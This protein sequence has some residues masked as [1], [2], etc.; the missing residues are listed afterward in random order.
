MT[1]AFAHRAHLNLWASISH[2]ADYNQSIGP[3]LTL[4]DRSHSI[5]ARRLPSILLLCFVL[6]A[7]PI[8]ISAQTPDPAPLRSVAATKNVSTTARNK[9][10]N[11]SIARV[12]DQAAGGSSYF[13]RF[14]RGVLRV[15]KAVLS[16]FGEDKNSSKESSSSAATEPDELNLDAR[17]G[18]KAKY[19]DVF[20]AVPAPLRTRLVERLKLL[21]DYQRTQQWEKQYDLLSELVTQGKGKDEFVKLNRHYYTE[22]V[23]D[24]LILDFTPHSLTAQSESVDYGEWTIFGCARLQKKGHTLQLY[25]SVSAYRQNNDW[26]FSQVGLVMQ[27]GGQ[28]ENCPYE[29]RK[30]Q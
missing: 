8:V 12:P 1:R 10:A 30:S 11:P 2:H 24:D 23:P 28:P 25:G 17:I 4:A 20:S 18:A 19:E 7:T 14:A 3:Q 22:V 13:K 5:L 6:L 21:I 16:A 29:S 27:V 26:Y 15:G 9:A